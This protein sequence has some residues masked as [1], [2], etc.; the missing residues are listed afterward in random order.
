LRLEYRFSPWGREMRR[1]E[2][3]ALLGGVAAWPHAARAQ[4]TAKP[5]VVGFLGANTPSTQKPSTEAFVQ[6]LRELG[7]TEGRNVIIEYRWAEG[8]VDRATGL[9][10]ELV[11][12]HVNV[13]FTHATQNVIAAKQA[14]SVIPIVFAAAGDPVG[15]NLVASL[16][17]PGGNVTGLSTQNIDLAGKRLDILRELNPALHRLAFL[18][19]ADNPGSAAEADE[20]QAIAQTHGV[21]VVMSQIRRADDIAPTI[22]ALE[23]HAEALYVQT[24]PIMNTNRVRINALALEARLLTISGFR[25]FVQANGLTSYGPNF[26]DMFRRAAEYVDK[27]LRGVKPR[28]LPVEQPTKFD[29]AIN[30][31][32]AKALGLTVP[33]TLL[34]RADEVIE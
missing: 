16:A 19:N 20:L 27:I 2:L 32:T 29:F 15:N 17:R 22:E 26:S 8:R 10:A 24:D 23:G 14:T 6:R 1:R 13:I 7:W 3:F 9:L 5:L 34:A 25:E 18:A 28:D 30:L 4:Q 31:Q 21:D 33:P 12:M 11:G